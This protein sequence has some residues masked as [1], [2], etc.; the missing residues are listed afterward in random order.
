[1]STLKA[2]SQ[3]SLGSSTPKAVNGI[4]LEESLDEFKSELVKLNIYN[5][6]R[7]NSHFL[8]RF[9]SIIFYLMII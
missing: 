8:T 7:M 1:M 9:L 4:P 3:S 2:A 6:E 5:D